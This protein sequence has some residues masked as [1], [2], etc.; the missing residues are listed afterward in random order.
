MLRE[1]QVSLTAA[2]SGSE[3]ATRRYV[4]AYRELTERVLE[5]VRKAEPERVVATG[6]G[7]VIAVHGRPSRTYTDLVLQ[8]AAYAPFSV[9]TRMASST[10]IF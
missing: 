8:C 10:L 6:P 1:L 7:L 9:F 2:L 5:A 4:R 3:P